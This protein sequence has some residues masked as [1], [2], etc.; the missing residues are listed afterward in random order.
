MNFKLCLILPALLVL[1]GCVDPTAI[2]SP[3]RGQ[4]DFDVDSLRLPALIGEPANTTTPQPPVIGFQTVC[5]EIAKGVGLYSGYYKN[6]GL[7]NCAYAAMSAVDTAYDQYETNLLLAVNYGSLAADLATL[8]LSAASTVAAAKATKTVLSATITAITGA[9]TA[10]DTDLLYK[11]SVTNVINAME[12]DR[13]KVENSIA[14]ALKTPES[15]S[16]GQLSDDLVNY[17]QAGT[18]VRGIVSLQGTTSAQAKACKQKAEH[19]KLAK[20]RQ[21]TDSDDANAAA[22]SGASPQDQCS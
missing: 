18:F 2:L 11:S 4:P 8:G 20:T 9:K 10:V 3:I 5:A 6:P 1:A 14:N 16:I 22:R 17:Y 13:A 7:T 12:K 21:V 15:Y 19:T